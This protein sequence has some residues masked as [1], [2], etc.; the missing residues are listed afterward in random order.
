MPLKFSDVQR[1]QLS[2]EKARAEA[3]AD[4][5]AGAKSC[6]ACFCTKGCIS[7][8]SSA[9]TVAQAAD[10]S[11]EVASALVQLHDE[12][13]KVLGEDALKVALASRMNQGI[14]S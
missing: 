4:V 7:S 8:L 12:A 2:I 5:Q 10:L 3:G 13:L 11:P 1:V 14:T 6:F 9:C